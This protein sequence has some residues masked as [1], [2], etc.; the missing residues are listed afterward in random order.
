MN[1]ISKVADEIAQAG[2]KRVMVAARHVRKALVES[3]RATFPRVS[4]DLAKGWGVRRVAQA[5]VL[6]GATNP[7]QHAHLLEF[8]TKER[9]VQNAF[10]RKGARMNVG[11]VKAKPFVEP[12]FEREASAVEDILNNPWI[13]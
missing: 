12:T 8:G 4:G 5:R 2:D 1:I 9:T 13:A 3:A 10:G 7:A 6:V 11:R